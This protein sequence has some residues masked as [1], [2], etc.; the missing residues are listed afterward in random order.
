MPFA[1]KE[2]QEITD[3]LQ[4]DHFVRPR[5]LLPALAVIALGLAASC[6]SVLDRDTQST[7]ALRAAGYPALV[8]AEDLT[9]SVP[10]PAITPQTARDLDARANGL[11]ARAER[12]RAEG[13][14][15][16]TKARTQAGVGG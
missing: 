15:A 12:L 2:W 11:R 8:P 1:P 6:T 14:D 3:R 9:A 13:V 7:Q 4:K 10:P 16:G 5:A